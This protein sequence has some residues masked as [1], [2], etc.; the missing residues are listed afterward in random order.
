MTKAEIKAWLKAIKQNRAWLAA[1]M[2]MTQGSVNQLLD[3]KRPI[4]SRAEKLLA[5]LMQQHPAASHAA[6]APAPA[7][8]ENVLL[9]TASTAEFAAWNQAAMSSGQLVADWAAGV[10]NDAA[11]SLDP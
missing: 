8:P 3:S 10:L 6:S 11:G 5:Q 9:V 7:V 2:A 1:Q 4:S